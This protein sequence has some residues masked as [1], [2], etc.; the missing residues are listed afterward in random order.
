VKQASKVES[1]MVEV[2][3]TVRYWNVG[4]EVFNQEV[5]ILQVSDLGED[6]SSLGFDLNLLTVLA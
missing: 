2:L 3:K 4:V 6:L 5:F 1:E